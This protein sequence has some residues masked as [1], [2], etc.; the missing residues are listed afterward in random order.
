MVFVFNNNPIDRL[1]CWI[2]NKYEE[3]THWYWH[4][5]P[6][7]V[8]CKICGNTMHSNIDK[9]SPE[10]CGWRNIKGGSSW[11]CHLCD[12]HR[13][14]HPYIELADIDEDILWESHAATPDNKKINKWREQRLE[15]LEGL[16]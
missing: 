10:E 11:I 2:Y 1:H 16:K 8:T 6:H 14:F 4:K 12:A 3:F 7:H 15:I 9:Y 5:S 13:D